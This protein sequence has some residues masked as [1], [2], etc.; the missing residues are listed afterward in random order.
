MGQPVSQSI[1]DFE[2]KPAADKYQML[3][4]PEPVGLACVLP[5]EAPSYA[6]WGHDS[7]N[8]IF[9]LKGKK[10]RKAEGDPKQ[11]ATR[12]LRA[13][14]KCDRVL[15]YS[16]AKFD[17]QV[18]DVGMGVKIPDSKID[19][20][21]FSRFLVDPRAPDFKLKPSVERVLGE[22]PEERDAV[23]EWLYEHGHTSRKKVDGRYVYGSKDNPAGKWI[24]KAP[25]ALVAWYA[26]ADCTKAKALH[27][28]D[29]KIVKRDGMLDAYQ[30]ELDVAPILRENERAGVRLDVALLREDRATY[31]KALA[32]VEEWLRKKL[33]A[34][35]G[36]N[37]DSDDEVALA[38]RKSGQVKIFPKTATGKDSVSKGKLTKEFFRDEE[39]YLALC[40]RSTVAY[41]MSQNIV[42]WSESPNGRA[43]TS[44]DQVRG[45]EKGGAKTGRITC[46]KFANI[47]KDP[48]GGKNPDYLVADDAKIRKLIG[49]PPIPLARRYILPEVG[50]L[51]GHVD[52]SQQEIRITAHF[53]EGRLAQAYRNNPREDIHKF[54]TKLINDASSQSYARD[55]IKHVN[56][57][58]FYGGGT[59]GLV[60]HPMLRLDKVY[61]CRLDCHHR[62][63]R[64]DA[65]KAAYKINNDWEE[66]LPDV[67]NLINRLK[68]MYQ[69][70]EP[71]RTIG[72]RLYHCKPDGVAAKGPRK[73][74]MTNFSYMAL[75]DLIQPSAADHL[76]QALVK[77]HRHSKRRASM[78][79]TVYDEIN[80]SAPKKLAMEQVKLLQ[81]VMES[82]PLDVPYRT[83]GDVRPCWGTKEA[84]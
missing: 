22:P 8:G 19:D 34:P 53:E 21:L 81:G 48:T 42:P 3:Y 52:W 73:G 39:V 14:V 35:A 70:G 6:S 7:E 66:G 41:V 10:L 57:R 37:W 13:A 33:R 72:G 71:I 77:W 64:C 40:Y 55:V 28:H 78:L 44:W 31:T 82:I 49:L 67:V 12:H 46:S 11:W 80:I 18:S 79:G 61:K 26:I 16:I 59:E 5:G 15:G 47:I 38:L 54:C 62:E 4:V 25:G 65:M 83:D 1:I 43:Y 24:S 2:T 45:A 58:K 23:Y 56:L 32:K 60:T 36:I 51:F 69:R 75:N 30:L 84:K 27:D 74:Q 76:K 68:S 29:M 17:V 63:D 50:E 9:V 20:G